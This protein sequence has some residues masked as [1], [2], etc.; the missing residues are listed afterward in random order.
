MTDPLQQFAEW[1]SYGAL[2]LAKGST[3]GA[4]L[5]F[6]IYDSLKIIF[7]MFLMIFMMGIIR[8]YI[9]PERIRKLLSNR[10][11]F[12]SNLGAS[13]FGAIT[14]FCSCSSIPIF[15]SFVE[16]GVPLGVAFSFLVTSPLI[17]EYLVVMMLSYLGLQV[18]VVYVLIGLVLGISAGMLIGRMNMEKHLAEDLFSC[19]ESHKMKGRRYKSFAERLRFGYSEAKDITSKTWLWVLAGVGIGAAIHGFIPGEAIN[20]AVNAT[21]IFAV[22]VAVLIGIPIYANCT[23]V[24]PIA[25]A[26]FDKGVPLGTSLAF[27]MSTA[28]LSLPEAVILR[29]AIKLPLLA[30]FFGIVALGI[31]IVGYLLNLI[32]PV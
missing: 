10:I 27:M 25:A 19:R 26:L 9:A 11:P 12:L 29:R 6:F 14:P 18:T 15:M 20:A 4:A 32:F 5:E 8:T 30:L 23:A 13:L 28:A 17:N 24:L 16:A 7:L 31:M 2:G 22:P 21:G 3:L 1:L